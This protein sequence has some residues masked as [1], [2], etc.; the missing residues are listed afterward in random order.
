MSDFILKKINKNLNPW[1]LLFT[2]YSSFTLS[3]GGKFIFT[4]LQIIS[5]NR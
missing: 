4:N 5:F 3:I 1:I 2:H